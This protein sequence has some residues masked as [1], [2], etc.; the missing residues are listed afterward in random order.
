MLQK[1]FDYESLTY[2][3]RQDIHGA[4][5]ETTIKHINQSGGLFEPLPFDPAANPSQMLE[6]VHLKSAPTTIEEVSFLADSAASVLSPFVR[7][8]LRNHRSFMSAVRYFMKDGVNIFPVTGPHKNIR[9]VAIWAEGW[10]ENL[11]NE[12]AQEQNGLGISRGVTTI[13][14]FGM[15]AS[16]V[17]QKI[18]HVFMSFP[19]TKTMQQLV[20]KYKAEAVQKYQESGEKIEPVDIEGLITTNN[21][22]LRT[23]AKHW[24]GS[25]LV[26]KI[27]RHSLG[28][29]LH[30]ALE[31]T[32]P[33]ISYGDDGK[34]DRI[35]LGHVADGT[36]DMIKNGLVLPVTLWDDDNYPIVEIGELTRVKTQADIRRIQQFQRETLIKKLGLT[37]ETV[38]LAS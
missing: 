22:N 35:Q 30:L 3:Q 38:T 20:E 28:K 4:L 2:E 8:T 1:S 15:A 24:L 9:D 13:G 14:A 23:E 18:G 7:E 25:D 32:T 27:G 19:R 10:Y 12:Q 29:S 36:I 16:E 26:H 37:E 11:D 6:V 31:G 21:K 33:E 34:P 17:V 5:A